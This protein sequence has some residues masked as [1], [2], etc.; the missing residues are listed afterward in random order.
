MTYFFKGPRIPLLI[1][2]E[3]GEKSRVKIV[4][5]DFVNNP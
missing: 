3:I 4:L 5:V 1:F 2:N